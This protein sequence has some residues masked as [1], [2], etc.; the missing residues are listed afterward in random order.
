[1]FYNLPVPLLKV[2]N[3]RPTVIEDQP[4][5]S[6][7]KSD[8]PLVSEFESNR[9]AF[10]RV[11]PRQQHDA[12]ER[13]PSGSY[14]PHGEAVTNPPRSRGLTRVRCVNGPLPLAI[15]FAPTPSL[16]RSTRPLL[17]SFVCEKARNK[18]GKFLA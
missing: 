9:I 6:L 11:K 17:S 15:A 16:V 8:P 14:Y 12:K 7:D 18:L 2:P 10:E 4:A 1:M 5:T 3:T 13:R